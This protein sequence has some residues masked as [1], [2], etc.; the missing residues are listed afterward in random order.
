MTSIAEY[1]YHHA[2]QT[3]DKTAVIFEGAAVS[4]GELWRKTV[5]CAHMLKRLGVQEG[6]RVVCQ[7]KYDLYFVAIRFAAHLCGAAFVP[8]DK[9][10]DLKRLADLAELLDARL[11]LSNGKEKTLPN[12]ILFDEIE[13]LLPE[14]ASMAGLSFP[15][16][17]SVADIVF[18]TGTTG[19]S[20]G[21]QLTQRNMAAR[22]LSSI[23]A[24]AIRPDD[25]CITMVPLN[26]IAPI[27]LL[28]IRVT[29]G[30]TITFLDGMTKLKLLFD[31]MDK[32]SKYS[33]TI[34]LP[35]AGIALL[36]RLSQNK[37]ADYAE[38]LRSFGTGSAAMPGP[39]QDFLKRM[40]PHS[41]LYCNYASSEC[42]V[43]SMR[44]YD[45]DSRDVTCCGKPY[46]TIDV[47]VVDD[48]FCPVP[49]GSVGL[50]TVKSETNMLGY[51]N[52]P[53][54]NDAVFHD[55]YFITSD[56]G[57]LDEEGFLYVLGRS[58]DMINIGGLKV[59][60]F[61]IENAALRIPGIEECICFGVPDPVTGRAVKLLIKTN[62][63]FT[64]S[65]ALVQEALSKVMDYYK[66]PKQIEIVDE[67]AKTANGKPNRKFYQEQK[68]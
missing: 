18:T 31:F 15:E 40:L 43:V 19:A 37:L 7:S 42:G 56:I 47:R 1:L 45:G 39:L 9:D 48:A 25:V 21:V 22:A 3:P 11:V 59:Y 8:A 16:P 53:D 6:D 32:Y 24:F 35:P 44:R 34:Y 14:D 62:D 57:Y 66:V 50:I 5:R 17:D 68:S 23:Q 28:D 12:C 36:Q 67:I 63:A 10:A 54:L 2:N 26:H 27:M 58:D 64:G 52:R 29:C 55:G 4:Y 20:K 60:P 38:R 51:Y 41:H 46:A 61:E 30:S 33:V 49:T 65:V 13:N